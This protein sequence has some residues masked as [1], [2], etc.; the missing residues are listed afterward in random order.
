MPD[1]ARPDFGGLKG[2]LGGISPGLGAQQA[3]VISVYSFSGVAVSEWLGV[4]PRA[5]RGLG[6]RPLLFPPLASRA[7]TMSVEFGE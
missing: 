1:A 6:P 2:R 7:G 5:P 3:M 4:P